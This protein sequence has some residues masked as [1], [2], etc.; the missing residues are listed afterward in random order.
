VIITGGGRLTT[1]GPSDEGRKGI[2]GF[3]QGL[4]LSGEQSHQSVMK[5]RQSGRLGVDRGFLVT[6]L[7]GLRPGLG[8]VD[9]ATTAGAPAL[10][11]PP[12]IG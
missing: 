4:P 8:A 6:A 12:R 5:L 9:L 10:A 1:L 2:S 7:G 3:G 11:H